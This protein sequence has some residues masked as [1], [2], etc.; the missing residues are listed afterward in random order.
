MQESVEDAEDVDHR[1]MVGHDNVGF[2]AVHVVHD[3]FFERPKGIA[4]KINTG[5]KAGVALQYFQVGIEGPSHKAQDERP[6][7]KDNRRAD[8]ECPHEGIQR[9]EINSSKES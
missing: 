4:P 6:E 5:P 9:N 3:Q 7:K 8:V 1:L 2:L